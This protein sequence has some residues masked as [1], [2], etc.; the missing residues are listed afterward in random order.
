MGIFLILE[1]FAILIISKILKF[2]GFKIVEYHI[3][4]RNINISKF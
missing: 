3:S 4:S 2:H 1:K